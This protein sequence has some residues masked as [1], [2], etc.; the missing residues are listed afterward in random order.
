VGV[1]EDGGNPR[2]GGVPWCRGAVVPLP[3]CRGAVVPL[4]WCR[5]ATAMVPWCR[6]ANYLAP[7]EFIMLGQG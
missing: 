1:A 3:W 2:D 4:P 5:G 7:S 6:G